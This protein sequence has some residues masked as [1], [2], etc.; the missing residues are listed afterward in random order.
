MKYLQKQNMKL[1]VFD[2]DGTIADTSEGILDSHKY[3]LST[4]GRAIPSDKELRKVIGGNLLNTYIE[5]FDFE[6]P[7]ARKAV[8][9]Y[10]K[11][12]AEVGIH[13]SILYPGF[14]EMVKKLKQKKY[15]IGIATLKAEKFVKVLLQELGIAD[16]FDSVCGMD[17][18]D[19]LDKARLIIKCM[20]ECRCKREDTVLVGDSNNDYLGAQKVNVKFIGVTYGFG[21]EPNIKYDFCTIPDT[22]TLENKLCSL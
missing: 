11:R 17:L 10:R 13:K 2:F 9:I 19:R 16:Y 15:K 8:D 20:E 6:E 1:V 5:T 22:R 4:M 21:F 14:A 7:Q 18:N 3:T 12:Y